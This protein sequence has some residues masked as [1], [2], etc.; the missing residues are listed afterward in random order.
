MQKLGATF[1][2]FLSD[3]SQLECVET[4]LLKSFQTCL[5]CIYLFKLYD[6]SIIILLAND[7][8]NICSKTGFMNGLYLQCERAGG[9][10]KIW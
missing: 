10:L 2:S 9:S 6:K 7:I 8:A 1:H 3:T 5:Y 4:N